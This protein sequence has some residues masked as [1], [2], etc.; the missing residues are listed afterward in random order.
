[1]S[2][3]SKLGD[4]VGY[5]RR[6]ALLRR[7]RTRLPT[8]RRR[9]AAAAHGAP[10]EVVTDSAAALAHAIAELIPNAAHN[11]DQYANNRINTT[12]DG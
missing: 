2:F 10:V 5:L 1:M 9:D 4:D 12:T 7:K 6:Q 11:T 8:P 3:R